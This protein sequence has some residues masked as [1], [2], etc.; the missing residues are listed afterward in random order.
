MNRRRFL[1][2]LTALTAA[3]TLAPKLIAELFEPKKS[4]GLL[5]FI[6][7]N[8]INYSGAFTVGDFNRHLDEIFK[9]QPGKKMAI[10]TDETYN[11]LKEIVN[12]KV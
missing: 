4:E 11:H 10:M 2:A 3:A 9:Y 12:G 6:S 8:P 7:N 5:D 1:K